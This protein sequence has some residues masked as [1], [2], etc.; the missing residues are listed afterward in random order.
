MHLLL[1]AVCLGV[2]N[3]DLLYYVMIMYSNG[4]QKVY[5]NVCNSVT[6]IMPGK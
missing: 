1:Y 6:I 3:N 5:T 2:R 4:Q